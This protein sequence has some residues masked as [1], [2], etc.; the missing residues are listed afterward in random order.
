MTRPERELEGIGAVAAGDFVAEAGAVAGAGEDHFEQAVIGIDGGGPIG[1]VVLFGV[2]RAP[3]QRIERGI[4][5]L[6][7]A[8]VAQPQI[9][10]RR[11]GQGVVLDEVRV[12]REPTR[13]EGEGA[14]QQ[15][16]VQI[17]AREVA[18]GMTLAEDALHPVGVAIAQAEGA[19]L[20]L[21]VERVEGLLVLPPAVRG[22]EA[23]VVIDQALAADDHPRLFAWLPFELGA[24]DL[25]VLRIRRRW[26]GRYDHCGCCCSHRAARR[27]PRLRSKAA[28]SHS[29]RRDS[30]ARRRSVM[31]SASLRKA[32]SST[33]SWRSRPSRNQPGGEGGV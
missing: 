2:F 32:S 11:E 27:C 1:V 8:G 13:A 7:F 9:A 22:N 26:A 10:V 16:G 17:P 21:D 31:A 14:V 30:R 19:D 23:V 33:I 12:E 3:L 5:E 24:V 29:T 6:H 28:G 25:E 15:M 20:V 18:V 4:G